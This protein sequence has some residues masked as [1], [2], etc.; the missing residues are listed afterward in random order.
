MLTAISVLTSHISR[1][2]KSHVAYGY[3]NKIAQLEECTP[4]NKLPLERKVE[5]EKWSD[6]YRILKLFKMKT[7][8]IPQFS[9]VTQ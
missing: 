1:A 7:Y 2:Q 5:L 3:G 9:S 8:S 4:G 6:L